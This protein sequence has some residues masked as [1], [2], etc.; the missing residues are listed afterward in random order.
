MPAYLAPLLESLLADP[1]LLYSTGAALLLL[2]VSASSGFGR[3]DFLALARPRTLLR[4]LG[5]V[6][7][8]FLIEAAHVLWASALPEPLPALTAG[9]HRLPL[10]LVA[11]VPE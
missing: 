10:H 2:A 9:L 1:V 6:A 3:R 5:A 8:A 4:V 7:V 11:L